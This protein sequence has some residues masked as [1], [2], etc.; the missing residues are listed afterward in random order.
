MSL[1]KI[2]LAFCENRSNI[3]VCL[4]KNSNYFDPNGEIND[5]E[6]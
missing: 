5:D 2:S 4:D 1:C 3:S 6:I